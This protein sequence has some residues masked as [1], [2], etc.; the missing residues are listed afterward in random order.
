MIDIFENFIRCFSR[1]P[2][3]SPE[4][5]QTSSTK[6]VTV[7]RY[8]SDIKALEEEYGEL[9]GK[10]ITVELQKLLCICP[11]DRH[12]IEAYQGLR[13]ALQKDYQCFLT[14]LSQKTRE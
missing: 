7:G 9:K 6:D 10:K 12:R 1:E 14:I 3:L 2:E 8:D 5:T 13:S 11:R 4:T